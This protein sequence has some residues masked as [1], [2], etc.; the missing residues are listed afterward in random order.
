[1]PDKDTTLREHCL[2]QL[3]RIMHY[4][5]FPKN[6]KAAIADYVNALL[7]AGTREG[8]TRVLDDITGQVWEWCPSAAVLRGKAYDSQVSANEQRRKCGNCGGAGAITI[9]YLATYEGKSW[10]AIRKVERLR[11]YEHS[12]SVRDSLAEAYASPHP[13]TVNQQVISA[14]KE[15]ECRK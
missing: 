11:D 2:A 9:F 3:G 5:G 13:P 14:A 1:M 8:V 7:V 10:A 12:I 15:C 4:G 6:E